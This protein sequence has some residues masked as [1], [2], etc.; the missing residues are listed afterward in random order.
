M[1]RGLRCSTNAGSFCLVNGLRFL[2]EYGNRLVLG[3]HHPRICVLGTGGKG[4]FDRGLGKVKHLSDSGSA[5]E[6][7][8]AEGPQALGSS[9]SKTLQPSV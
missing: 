2:V 7:M 1:T 4:S 5:D 8:V 3:H 9:N 6:P